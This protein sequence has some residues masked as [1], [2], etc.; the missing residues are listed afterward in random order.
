[1]TGEVGISKLLIHPIRKVIL[2]GD[3][4]CLLSNVYLRVF[5][6]TPMLSA[7]INSV[8]E[9]SGLSHLL[10]EQRHVGSNPTYATKKIVVPKGNKVK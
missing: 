2:D 3:R 10:W 6:S 1:M 5:G 9:E 8:V 7:E 4:A